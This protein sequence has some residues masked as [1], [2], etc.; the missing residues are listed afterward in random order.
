MKKHVLKKSIIQLGLFLVAVLFTLSGMNVSAQEKVQKKVVKL[1]VKS[2]E[3][4]LDDDKDKRL[5]EVKVSDGET[6]VHEKQYKDGKIIVEKYLEGEEAEKFLSDHAENL[7]GKNIDIQIGADDKMEIV[8]QDFEGLDVDKL[9]ENVEDLYINPD[10][11]KLDS[12]LFVFQG[13]GNINLDSIRIK[14]EGLNDLPESIDVEAILK[15]IEDVD[16]E[17]IEKEIENAKVMVIKDGKL[18]YN[19]VGDF[20]SIFLKDLTM[21]IN[22]EKGVRKVIVLKKTIKIE[23]MDNEAATDDDLLIDD[24]QVYPNPGDAT[25]TFEFENN[26]SEK[27]DI[28]LLSLNGKELYHESCFEKG[29]ISKTIDTADLKEGVYLL[30]ITQGEKRLSKRLIIK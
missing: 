11:L 7:L 2:G 17:A 18:M 20:D 4:L 3:I 6:S 19:D 5:I 16:F 10:Q 22:G 8:L 12:N 15:H 21:D 14:V 27:I 29:K 9:L 1:K 25:I 24:L 13:D 28:R 26:D 30:Q 23:D